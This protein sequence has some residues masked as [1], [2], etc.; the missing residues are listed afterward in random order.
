MHVAK[1]GLNATV[2][3]SMTCEHRNPY[4]V[5]LKSNSHGSRGTMLVPNLTDMASAPTVAGEVFFQEMKIPSGGRTAGKISQTAHLSPELI[6][7]SLKYILAHNKTFPVYMEMDVKTDATAQFMFI[8][9]QKHDVLPVKYCG[10]YLGLNEAMTSLSITSSMVCRDTYNEMQNAVQLLDSR[11][12]PV[13]YVDNLDP[14]ED[15]L[16]NLEHEINVGAGCVELVGYSLGVVLW[17]AAGRM[18]YR[19]YS[20]SSAREGVKDSPKPAEDTADVQV[21]V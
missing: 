8:S 3:A 11:S 6:K 19:T 4:R 21:A 5:T 2:H 18:L 16:D 10:Y 1:F 15:T 12:G 14:T 9:K 17:I 13:G 20:Q 7:E